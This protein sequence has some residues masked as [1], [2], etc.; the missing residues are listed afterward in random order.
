MTSVMSLP[1]NYLSVFYSAVWEMRWG[2]KQLWGEITFLEVFGTYLEV[3]GYLFRTNR[4]ASMFVKFLQLSECFHPGLNWG[5]AVKYNFWQFKLQIAPLP[6]RGFADLSVILE[7]KLKLV[8]CNY[9]CLPT[10]LC[11]HFTQQ[12]QVS[13]FLPKTRIFLMSK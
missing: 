3:L 9:P 7:K 13:L 5:S 8:A 10:R 12:F 11:L 2:V 1:I 6:F 4:K